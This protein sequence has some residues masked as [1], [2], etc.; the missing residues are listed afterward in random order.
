M[1]KNK[2]SHRGAKLGDMRHRIYLH[3]RL[4][5]SPAFGS[6]DF[7]EEFIGDP[8]WAAIETLGGKIT[9]DD[10]GTEQIA[11][12]AVYIRFC[13][14]SSQNFIQVSDGRR[15]RILQSED[16]DER[17]EYVKL[18]CTDRGLNEASKA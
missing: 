14:V 13:D 3:E 4:I 1:Q 7:D 15:F 5:T 2:I 6:I 12:H 18:I 9:F 17:H 8:K 11:T 16:Y 10:V